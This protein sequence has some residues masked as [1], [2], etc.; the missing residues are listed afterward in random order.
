MSSLQRPSTGVDGRPPAEDL[1]DRLAQRRLSCRPM[2]TTETTSAS[3]VYEVPEELRDF[4][5]LVRR[6]AQEQIAPRAAEIDEKGEYPWD[7]RELLASHDVLGLPFPTEYGG[8]GT[9]T[10]M[11]QIA[12]E[13]IAQGLRL[14]RADPDGPGARHAADPAVRLRRAQGAA[15]A[16][17]APPASG[18]RPSRCQRARGGLGPGLDADDRRPGRRR[19]GHQRLQE[20]D[21]QRGD[22]RLLR[23]LRRHRPREPPD[24]RLRGREGPARVL[25]RRSSSTSSGSRARRPARPSSR[26]C[27]SRPRT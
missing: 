14:E 27:G 9:G 5:D 25:D 23:R 4:R 8:T 24:H 2:S 7:I 11:L 26:T 16:E 22:R 18:R 17:A 3:G 20:L 21:H 13:E 15:A 12:V 10:L 1:R 19:V 6:L